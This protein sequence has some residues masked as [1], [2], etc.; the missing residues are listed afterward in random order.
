MDFW[1]QIIVGKTPE[2]TTPTPNSYCTHASRNTILQPIQ[3]PYTSI[4][5]FYSY[6]LEMRRQKLTQINMVFKKNMFQIYTHAFFNGII[7]TIVYVTIIRNISWPLPK[8]TMNTPYKMN[9]HI[10]TNQMSTCPHVHILKINYQLIRYTHT[11]K[12]INF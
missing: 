1:C 11:R 8:S 12:L 7:L 3:H 4:S 10:T 9:W 6:K 5:L 2:V